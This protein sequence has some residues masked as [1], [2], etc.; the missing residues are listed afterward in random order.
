M[1]TYILTLHV[2]FI[3]APSLVPCDICGEILEKV[4]PPPPPPKKNQILYKNHFFI[5][6][7]ISDTSKHRFFMASFYLKMCFQ[8][9]AY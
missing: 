9:T 5:L 6:K 4:L 7:M 1:K 8:E 3:F 2:T